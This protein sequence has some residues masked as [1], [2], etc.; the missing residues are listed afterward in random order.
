MQSPDVARCSLGER[1]LQA[2]LS[3]P[4]GGDSAPRR[5]CWAPS[6]PRLATSQPR[7]LLLL[8]RLHMAAGSR[9]RPSSSCLLR[10]AQTCLGRSGGLVPLSLP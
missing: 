6:T 10:I 3:R 1:E 5:A 9:V 2:D 7:S 4:S 8:A